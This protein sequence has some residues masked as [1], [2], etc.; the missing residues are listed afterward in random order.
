MKAIQKRLKKTDTVKNDIDR[1]DV[2]ESVKTRAENGILYLLVAPG[3]AGCKASA[4]K[5][6][7]IFMVDAAEAVADWNSYQHVFAVKYAR[8]VRTSAN[9]AKGLSDKFD[10]LGLKVWHKSEKFLMADMPLDVTG[11]KSSAVE[12]AIAKAWGLANVSH[13]SPSEV[14]AKYGTRFT[15]YLDLLDTKTLQGYEVKDPLG[16]L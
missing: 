3:L 2:Y 7:T 5:A 8:G 15:C 11:H 10:G 14:N 1:E 13:M 4:H 9:C 12:Q 6:T 16:I